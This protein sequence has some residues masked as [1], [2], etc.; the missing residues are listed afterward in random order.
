MYPNPIVKYIVRRP[1][2]TYWSEHRTEKVAKRECKKANII[3][4]P[5][6]RVFA[7]HKDGT[8]TGPY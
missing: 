6:H 4:S 3:C 2:H 5:G 7:E 1:G 8:V